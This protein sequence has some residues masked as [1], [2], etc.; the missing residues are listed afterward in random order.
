M[1]WVASRGRPADYIM[2]IVS[3]FLF[4]F[5][6]LHSTPLDINIRGQSPSLSCSTRRSLV[7]DLS[8]IRAPF[9]DHSVHSSPVTPAP[10]SSPR[11]FRTDPGSAT[12]VYPK[13]CS[14][15]WLCISN[16]NS[17][18]YAQLIYYLHAV[19][20]IKMGPHCISPALLNVATQIAPQAP[21]TFRAV[22][23]DTAWFTVYTP[24]PLCLRV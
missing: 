1:A 3:F 4:L 6:S 7:L 13:R 16:S 2:F 22:G 24:G 9:P 19:L 12:S 15:Y 14:A 11:L 17:Q 18:Y 20:W 23:E 5:I 8:R 10:P 21:F